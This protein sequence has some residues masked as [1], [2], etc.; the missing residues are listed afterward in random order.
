MIN[1]D[2]EVVAEESC[3]TT[4]GDSEMDSDSEVVSAE[5]GWGTCGLGHTFGDKLYFA[6]DIPEEEWIPKKLVAPTVPKSAPQPAPKRGKQPAAC[7][8]LIPVADG[9]HVQQLKALCTRKQQEN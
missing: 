8:Q 7:C 9:E 6:W 4:D 3:P 5:S 1:S 2:G